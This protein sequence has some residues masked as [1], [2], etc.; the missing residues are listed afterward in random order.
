MLVIFAIMIMMMMAHGICMF[1]FEE[2]R[3]TNR[4]TLSPLWAISGAPLHN[5][6]MVRY[7]VVVSVCFK[8]TALF[9]NLTQSLKPSFASSCCVV[10]DDSEALISFSAPAS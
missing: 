6:G 7:G 9:K 3:Q 4:E 2:V 1:T 5:Y 10:A 8:G